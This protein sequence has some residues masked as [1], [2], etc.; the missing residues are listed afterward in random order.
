MFFVQGFQ[1]RDHCHQFH[2]IISG[3]AVTLRQFFFH[4]TPFQ[5]GTIAAR[6]GISPGSAI[7]VDDEFLFRQIESVLKIFGNIISESANAGKLVHD[8]I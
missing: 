2:S 1:C 5:D 8:I 6:T 7:G 4:A 3:E